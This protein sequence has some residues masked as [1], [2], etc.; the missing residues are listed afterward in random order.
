MLPTNQIIIEPTPKNKLFDRKYNLTHKEKVKIIKS[1]E[2]DDCVDI[3]PNTNLRYS[4]AEVFFFYKTIEVEVYGEV[5][6]VTLYIKEYID[7]R[8]GMDMVI[9]ISF[10]EEGLH[11]L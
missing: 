10:H 2:V 4:D 5:E 11:E 3:Q 7:D 8:D 9:V 6:T 1:L